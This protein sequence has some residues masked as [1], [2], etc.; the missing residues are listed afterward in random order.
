MD[1]VYHLLP[2]EQC[3]NGVSCRTSFLFLKAFLIFVAAAYFAFPKSIN[4]GA[5]STTG[6]DSST[7]RTLSVFMSL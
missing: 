7:T 3:E 2:R 1:D 4:T 6:P 5:Y